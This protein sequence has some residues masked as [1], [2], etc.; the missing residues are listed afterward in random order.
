MICRRGLRKRGSGMPPRNG[1]SGGRDCA[2]AAI[3]IPAGK[4]AYGQNQT[5]PTRMQFCVCQ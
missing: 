1:K 5:G 2:S 4:K 3:L